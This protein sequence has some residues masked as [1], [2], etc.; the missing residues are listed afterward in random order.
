[1]GIKGDGG[2]SCVDSIC[3]FDD[4]VHY[5][6]V[7][8]MKPVKDAERQHCRPRDICVLS[9]VKDLHRTDVDNSNLPEVMAEK[10]G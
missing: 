2:R 6:L 8:E 9:A 1:M 4:P 3:T 10:I 7:A 5:A